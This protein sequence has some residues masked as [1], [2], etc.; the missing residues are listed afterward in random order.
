MLPRKK[1][2]LDSIILLFCFVLLFVIALQTAVSYDDTLKH[3]QIINVATATGIAKKSQFDVGYFVVDLGNRLSSIQKLSWSTSTPKFL[4]GDVLLSFILYGYIVSERKKYLNEKMYGS[5][6][7]GMPSQLA[8]LFANN[9]SKNKIKENFTEF[10]SQLISIIH[11]AFTQKSFSYYF[12]QYKLLMHSTLLKLEHIRRKYFNADMLLT[13]T[14][15]IC[16][17]N[18]ELNNNTVVVGGPGSLKTRGYVIPNI[19]QA[20]SS[21]VVT[22]PKGEILAK[23]GYFLQNIKHYKIKV[24]NLLEHNKSTQYNPF[25]YLHREREGWE[26]RVLNLIET[27]IINTD[28]GKE[29]NSNDPFWDKAE[30]LILQSLFFAV[31]EAFPANEQNMNTVLALLSWLEVDEDNIDEMC[32]LDYFFDCFK[33][34]YG[35]DHI[36]YQQYHEFRSK[37]PGK[38]AKSIAITESVRLA[39]F[40]IKGIKRIFSDDDMELEN[41][42]ETKT[43]IFV[44]V[45]PVHKT[46]N[47]IAGMLFTQLFDEINY[48]AEVKHRNDGGQLPIPC[49]FILDEFR[50]TAKIPNFISILSY[51]RSL[52]GS[53]TTIIQSLDQIKAMY[54][55]EWGAIIDNS[56]T[57]L[58]LGKLT[59]VETLKYFSDLLGQATFD[60][61]STSHSLGRQSSSTTNNDR[62][63]RKLLDE[64]ELR[65]LK[66]N[67]CILFVNGYDPF[68]SE[69]YNCKKHKNYRF[70]SEANNKYS[71]EYAPD[72]PVRPHGEDS[73]LPEKV[74]KPALPETVTIIVS[75]NQIEVAEHIKTHLLNS[76][77]DDDDELAVNDGEA[78][79]IQSSIDLKNRQAA[80][81]KHLDDI[82]KIVIQTEKGDN[83]QLLSLM[84]NPDRVDF[85]N[86]DELEPNDGEPSIADE[87]DFLGDAY[88]QTNEHANNV[89][90]LYRDI[91]EDVDGFQKSLN[92][93]DINQLS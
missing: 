4:L 56:S 36:A 44:I 80:D 61:K 41:I 13:E 49:R 21:Y 8:H 86:D 68:Y 88:S 25:R 48:C 20:H 46:F 72:Q 79:D 71:F 23:T 27:I 43:A 58:Y 67:C 74:I 66:S 26:E 16:L 37:A 15:H 14:E 92:S 64:A 70:T 22:D 76:D 30:R 84:E 29:L 2:A 55:K 18:E 19:L 45:P 51:I 82:N 62:Y 53:I 3:P 83:A 38:T 34:E 33:K 47:F 24:L 75:D 11:D 90:A 87:Y 52:G 81:L 9:I 31:M 89:R 5:S 85:D 7:W 32:D 42:G 10:C 91:M 28:G 60:K 73:S 12:S 69:K 6:D 17:Y 39:P 50:N 54:E 1:S 63:G 77:F 59:H 35:E 65:K 78:E 57:L 93:F 40:R